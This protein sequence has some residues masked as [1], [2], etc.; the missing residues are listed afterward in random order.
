MSINSSRSSL[1][2]DPHAL[3]AAAAVG[4][5]QNDLELD[6][7]DETKQGVENGAFVL[8]SENGATPAGEEGGRP[9]TGGDAGPPGPGEAGVGERQGTTASQQEAL[10]REATQLPGA[11][12]E[13]EG[14]ARP[15]S[16][17]PPS[18]Q[19]TPVAGV[20][21]APPDAP[22]YRPPSGQQGEAAGG[23]TEGE[24]R[25]DGRCSGYTG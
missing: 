5:A 21:E 6:Q 1:G 10:S 7:V 23:A 22:D 18:R 13:E 3:G 9:P 16:T 17:R 25:V 24:R 15:G 8:Q 20:A 4:M 11:V 12:L 14:V 2:K 19:P